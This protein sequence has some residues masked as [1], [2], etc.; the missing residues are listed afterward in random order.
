MQTVYEHIPDTPVRA[1]RLLHGTPRRHNA[2]KSKDLDSEGLLRIYRRPP[3]AVAFSSEVGGPNCGFHLLDTCG[4]MPSM[5]H[6]TNLIPHPV[7]IA[8]F[9]KFGEIIGASC[10]PKTQGW[11][12][13]SSA[14]S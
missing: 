7:M 8:V 3:S 14:L 4:K 11:L 13:H 5:R 9:L 2:E 12:R 1:F 10:G 6:L